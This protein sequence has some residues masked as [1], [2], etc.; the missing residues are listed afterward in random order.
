MELLDFFKKM[1]LLH[2]SSRDVKVGEAS[3]EGAG[4]AAQPVEEAAVEQHAA[5]ESQSMVGTNP[6]DYSGGN[7]KDSAAEQNGSRQERDVDDK[8]GGGC[9]VPLSSAE[10]GEVSKDTAAGGKEG[11]DEGI[12]VAIESLMVLAG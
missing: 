1:K 6:K 3:G 9:N 12:H 4:E 7:F 11:H 8:N 2:G 5:V 10:N